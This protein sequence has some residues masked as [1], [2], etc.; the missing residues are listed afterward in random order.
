MCD[1]AMTHLGISDSEKQSIYTIVAALLHL[2]NVTFEEN[3]EDTKGR[4][5]LL[6]SCHWIAF[7]HC[8]S[9]LFTC[10]CKVSGYIENSLFT[11]TVGIPVGD[12]GVENE[13]LSSVSPCRSLNVTEMRRF[14][15]ITVKNGGPCQCLHG[16]LRT[17][18]NVYQCSS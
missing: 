4:L 14:L 5:V 13:N 16:R 1:K 8:I 6:K 12:P 3:T 2:G 18:R 11:S 7:D 10:G 17:L 15:G 9:L